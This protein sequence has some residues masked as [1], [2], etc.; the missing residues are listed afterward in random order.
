MESPGRDEDK[1]V[2]LLCGKLLCGYVRE[3]VVAK[4][5]ASGVQRLAKSHGTEVTGGVL[6]H[7][8][9]RTH[10]IDAN[11]LVIIGK[12]RANM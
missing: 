10:G 1:R 12:G 2:K 4:E 9:V 5:E 7:T 11:S 6:A 8:I 3:S